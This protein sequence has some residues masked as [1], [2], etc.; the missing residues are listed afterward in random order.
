MRQVSAVQR[1]ASTE[2]VQA[3]N[4]KLPPLALMLGL[5]MMMPTTLM[6]MPTALMMMVQPTHAAA[7]WHATKIAGWNKMTLLRP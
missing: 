5:T 4:N 2:W 7:M 6:M 3:P 1:T